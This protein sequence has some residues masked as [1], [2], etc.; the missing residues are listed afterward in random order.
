MRIYSHSSLGSFENCPR[1][2]WYQYIGKPPV[3][4][5][6]TIEAFLGTCVHETLEAL[7]RL[8][9][10]G[11]LLSQD[12]TLEEF[13]AIWAKSWS[14]TIRI[15]SEELNAEDYKRAGRE[16]LDSRLCVN[17]GCFRA[18]DDCGR[19]SKVGRWRRFGPRDQG[20][21]PFLA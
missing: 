14:D 3:E 8:R 16:V 1:Q 17:D 4:R 19:V 7:Y 18:N 9:L 15:V 6:D 20:R 5:V 21:M 10:R 12:G 11:R 13:E 2:Y